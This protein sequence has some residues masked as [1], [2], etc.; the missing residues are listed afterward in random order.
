[1]HYLVM[2]KDN[3]ICVQSLAFKYVLNY[4]KFY[5]MLLLLIICYLLILTD[6]HSC[7]AVITQLH[8]ACENV[9]VCFYR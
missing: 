2:I 8:L 5:I 1:M 6:L 9:L 3:K 4:L 7:Q